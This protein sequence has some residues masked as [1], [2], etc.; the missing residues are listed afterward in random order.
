MKMSIKLIAIMFH[1]ICIV[2]SI[3]HG[4]MHIINFGI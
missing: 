3:M 2:L 1:I 4:V